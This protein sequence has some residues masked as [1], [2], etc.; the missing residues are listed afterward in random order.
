MNNTKDFMMVVILKEMA[1]ARTNSFF[2]RIVLKLRK[3]TAKSQ[4][5]HNAKYK[6]KP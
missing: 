6:A 4:R 2:S 5:G 3:Q 1:F